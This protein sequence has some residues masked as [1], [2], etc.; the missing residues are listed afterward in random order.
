MASLTSLNSS[1]TKTFCDPKEVA[2]LDKCPFIWKAF[3]RSGYRTSFAEDDVTMGMFSHK[4]YGFSNQPTT[5]Y[6]RPFALAAEKHLD[7]KY[8]GSSIFCLGYDN[9]FDFVYRYAVDFATAYKN[10]PSF[11]LF[12]TNSLSHKDVID[13]S[14]MDDRVKYYLEEL[15]HRGIL[16]SSAVI[17]FSDHGLSFG[18]V[19]EL[20]VNN[21]KNL[22]V[23]S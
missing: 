21:T 7:I 15:K 20:T 14:S 12:W 3:E 13:V 2:G 11:G 18:L 5:H 19:R 10:E 23:F 4:K 1:Q 16:E 9:Y 8:R 6:F 17:F 22:N